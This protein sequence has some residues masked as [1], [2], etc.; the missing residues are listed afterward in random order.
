MAAR[1]PRALLRA[2]LRQA[3]YDAL[4]ASNLEEALAYPVSEANRGPVRLVIF[5]QGVIPDE[6]D[7]LVA[8]LLNRHGE[9]ST[10][11]LA[12]AVVPPRNAQWWGQVI[13]RPFSIADVMGAVQQLL[14]LPPASAPPLD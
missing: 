13:Q 5:D 6:Q 12:N 11:L 9:P 7:G 1:S 14:A 4:G 3:G 10:L 2:A 8:R